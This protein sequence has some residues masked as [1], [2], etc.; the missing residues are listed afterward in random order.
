M[1]NIYTWD[2]RH[3]MEAEKLEQRIEYVEQ[4]SKSWWKNVEKDI[5]EIKQ[6]LHCLPDEI[7]KRLDEKTDLKIDAKIQSLEARI[8]RWI[9]GLSVG[10]IISVAVSIIGIFLNGSVK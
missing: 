7:V 6:Q 10:F 4:N 3:K 9:A 2:L 8:Y 5:D 1:A